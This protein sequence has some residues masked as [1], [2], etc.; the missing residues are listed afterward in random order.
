MKDVAKHQMVVILDD[1]DGV[2]RH[3]RFKNPETGAMHFDPLTWPGHLCYTGDMGTY[4]F[5]RLEDM[6]VF[7]RTDREH[8]HLGNGKTLAINPQYW[9]EKLEAADRHDGF[10][11]WS[12]EEFE[13]RIR[14]DFGQWLTDNGMLA[15]Q[16][17]EAVER[18]ESEIISGL[19]E[20]SQE[21]AYRS[22]IDFEIDGQCPFQDWW[23]VDTEEYAYRFLCCCYALAWGI[24]KYDREKSAVCGPIMSLNDK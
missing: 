16:M 8:L 2:Y 14:E 11:K 17:E 9:G 21:S 10:R 19:D 15:E 5:H 6:F 22:V 4:V 3:I 20:G 18:L 7:F 12:K 1:D 13:K 23:E 24:G